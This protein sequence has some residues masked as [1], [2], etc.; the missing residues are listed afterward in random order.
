MFTTALLF[1]LACGGKEADTSTDTASTDGTDTAEETVEDS[2]E[3]TTGNE[4]AGDPTPADL[5]CELYSTTCGDWSAT[6]AC[7]DWYNAAEAG[8]DGDTSGATQSCYEYHLAAAANAED[9]AGV[10][11]HCAHARGEADSNGNAPCQ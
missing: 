1:F 9:Q 3:A 8:A 5:F 11:M 6:T 2:G 10:D 7:E 4:G